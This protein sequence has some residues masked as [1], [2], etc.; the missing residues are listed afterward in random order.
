VATVVI[1][2]RNTYV[3]NEIGKERCCLGKYDEILIW[4]KRMGHI[5]FDNIIKIKRKEEVREIIKISKLTNILC[6]NCLQGKQTRT[7]FK[8]NDYSTTKLLEIVHTYLCGL[9]RK[10]GLNGEQ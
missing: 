7:K 9:K 10:K 6:K 4:H 2:P 3:L 5:N 8:S 1:N